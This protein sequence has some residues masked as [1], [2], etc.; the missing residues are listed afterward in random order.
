MGHAISWRKGPYCYRDPTHYLQNQ[1][2]TEESSLHFCFPFRTA[3]DECDDEV[4][5]DDV[6]LQLPFTTTR[7]YKGMNI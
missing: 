5:D 2:K 3:N 7:G 4:D 6:N 1:H